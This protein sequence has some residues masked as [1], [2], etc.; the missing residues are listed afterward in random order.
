MFCLT[1]ASFVQQPSG[2]IQPI[3]KTQSIT[4]ELY[5]G[6]FEFKVFLEVV[7]VCFTLYYIFAEAKDWYEEFSKLY[8]ER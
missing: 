4:L 8:K 5:E 6:D 3:M 7:F 1:A 2:L